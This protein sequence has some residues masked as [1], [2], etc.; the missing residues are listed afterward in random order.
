MIMIQAIQIE[1]ILAIEITA[2]TR[3]FDEEGKRLQSRWLL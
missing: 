1:T 2:G 3:G